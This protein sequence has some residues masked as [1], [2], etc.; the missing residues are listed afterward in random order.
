MKER[1]MDEYVLSYGQPFVAGDGRVIYEKRLLRVR[2]DDD[3]NAARWAGQV[4]PYEFGITCN[5]EKFLAAPINLW[6]V[7]SP[8]VAVD[9]RAIPADHNPQNLAEMSPPA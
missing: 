1:R 8:T 4:V 6:R 3:T 5:G 7:A 2:R 9:L